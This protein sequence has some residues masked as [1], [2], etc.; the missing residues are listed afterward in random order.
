MHCMTRMKAGHLSPGHWPAPQR[1]ARVERPCLPKRNHICFHSISQKQDAPVKERD[2]WKLSPCPDNPYYYNLESFTATADASWEPA[3]IGS[4][5]SD[6]SHQRETKT[7][8]SIAWST[9]GWVGEGERGVCWALSAL[10]NCPQFLK[11]R[12]GGKQK[13]INSLCLE[14]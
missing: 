1:L 9:S 10:R 5:F 4:N 3:S 7:F 8:F 2:L 6:S 12:R 14:R 13:P 11:G